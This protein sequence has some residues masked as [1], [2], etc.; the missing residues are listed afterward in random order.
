M[1]SGV[2]G[3]I[4]TRLTQPKEKGESIIVDGQKI[5]LGIPGG[6]SGDGSKPVP[7]VSFTSL[8]IILAF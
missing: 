4:E 6:G 5:A 3:L 7:G 1:R 8:D 2:S